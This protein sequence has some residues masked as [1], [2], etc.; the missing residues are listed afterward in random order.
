MQKLFEASDLAG[1]LI[2]VR[3]QVFVR[4]DSLSVTKL[5]PPFLIKI[6]LL[7]VFTVS[8]ADMEVMVAIMDLL[9]KMTHRSSEF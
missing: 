2:T 4:R 5:Y 7:Q 3:V 6:R 9:Q 1:T 8:Q